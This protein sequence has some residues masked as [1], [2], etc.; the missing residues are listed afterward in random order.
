LASLILISLHIHVIL[1]M[2]HFIIFTLTAG[3]NFIGFRF[4][5][6]TNPAA[7]DCCYPS[8][9]LHGDLDLFRTSE[10]HRSLLR[11]PASTERSPF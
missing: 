8:D 3:V 5:S 2:P 4:I 6:S 9:Y 1:H 10:I 7:T 11:A